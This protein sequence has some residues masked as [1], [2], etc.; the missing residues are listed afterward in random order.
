MAGLNEWE[1]LNDNFEFDQQPGG[2][3][4]PCCCC[5]HRHQLL[6]TDPCRKCEHNVMS[7]IE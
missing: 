3:D 4:F 6:D 7:T 1:V 5:K 2:F